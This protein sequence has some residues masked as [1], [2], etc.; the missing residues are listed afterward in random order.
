MGVMWEGVGG[1]GRLVQVMERVKT[2]GMEREGVR[3][4][5]S[6]PRIAIF[7]RSSKFCTQYK[8]N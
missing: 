4:R 3:K 8:S 7:H 2:E 5:V 6:F 1:C